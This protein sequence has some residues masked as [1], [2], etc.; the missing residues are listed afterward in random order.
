[1]TE[2]QQEVNQ[3]LE[4]LEAWLTKQT[5]WFFAD[6][7]TCRWLD[8]TVGG[9]SS[10]MDHGTLLGL[11]D[12]DHNQ[13]LLT[14]ASND[15]VTGHLT[16]TPAA[17]S[18][19]VFQ[20]NQAD[21]T[22]V[23]TVDTTNTLLKVAGDLGTGLDA[24]DAL[25]WSM[26]VGTL[27][28]ATGGNALTGLYPV[29]QNV[30]LVAAGGGTLAAGTY[31][32][33]VCSE[34]AAS[35]T[36]FSTGSIE[37][38]VTIN[39][40]TETSIV[41]TWDEVTG[42]PSYVVFSSLVSMADGTA[43]KAHFPNGLGHTITALPTTN[44]VIPSTNRA[45][46][47]NISPTGGVFGGS[48]W[49]FGTNGR[50]DTTFILRSAVS[51]RNLAIKADGTESSITAVGGGNELVLV[52]KGSAVQFKANDVQVGQF[53]STGEF[54]IDG[55]GA[56]VIKQIIKGAA[57]QSANLQ[58]WQDSNAAVML[59]VQPDG[60]LEFGDAVDM[61]FNTTTGTKIGT[62]T[63]QKLG[64][65]NTTPVVQ[66]VHIADPTGGATQD[67]EARTAINAIL[68]VLENVGLTAAA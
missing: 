28:G 48:T 45:K 23:L 20:V 35:T 10:G 6:K 65:F 52:S 17:D 8:V 30:A 39:G 67:A 59:S 18:T 32:V 34:D 9:A 31:Y 25:S 66:A 50:S 44:R 29:P 57:S 62:A 26:T 56:A 43:Q 61:V 38:S 53:L 15:P 19:T 1:M 14:D 42:S 4:E 3:K 27:R 54:E 51:D 49:V 46:A 21:T 64:F 40:T 2:W 60:D 13:Y 55:S 5:S 58:E 47:F 41:V 7:I 36:I 68:V 12:N 16:I 22:N 37:E 63:N 11:T 24:L 33:R